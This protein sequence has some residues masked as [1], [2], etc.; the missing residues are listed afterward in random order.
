MLL[1][2]PWMT[3]E[4]TVS[5]HCLHSVGLESVKL[6]RGS[7]TCDKTAPAPH[8][9]MSCTPISAIQL[10]RLCKKR[11]PCFTVLVS[12]DDQNASKHITEGDTNEGLMATAR[13]QTMLE[14]HK[15]VFEPIKG[16]PPDRG[17]GHTIPW[18]AD[19]KPPFRSPCRLSPLETKEVE[20]QVRELL[21]LGLIEPSTSPYGAPV[22][23]VKK[24]DGTL[25]MCVDDR[26]LKPM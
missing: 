19:Q 4:D 1:G 26:A 2:H 21:R 13:L 25:R 18:H 17:V 7:R 15:L 3:A 11:L 12:K 9:P 16:L 23:F 5:W 22:L 8:A 14:K 24:K 10:K 6:R 20:M